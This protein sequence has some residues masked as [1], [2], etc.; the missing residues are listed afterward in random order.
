MKLNRE[1]LHNTKFWDEANIELPKNNIEE[2]IANT[3]INPRWLHFGA[4]NI[5]RAFPGVLQQQLLNKNLSDY[6]IVVAEGYDYEIIDRMYRPQ[7][8]LSLV[9]TLKADG[10]TQ[11]QVISSIVES[12]RVHPTYREDV[13]RLEEIITNPSLEMISFTITEKGYSITNPKGE[14]VG[15]I[16]N[17]LDN[18]L[19]D[20]QTFLGILV[21]N[22]YKRYKQNSAPI[23]LV[24][25]DNVSHNGDKL[26]NAVITIAQE[27]NKKGKVEDGFVDY[28]LDENKVSFPWSMI[29]KI[30]PRP[31][32]TVQKQLEELGYEDATPIITEKG[33]FISTFVNAEEAQYLVIEDKFPNGRPPL[34][35]VGVIFTYKETVDK[36]EKMKVCTCLNPLHTVLAIYGCLL[37]YEKIY[38]EMQDEE[39]VKF[40]KE[41]GYNEGLPVVVNPE[42]IDPKAFI[43][44]VIQVRFANPFMPDTP[45]R[46]ATDTS[47]KLAIRFGETIK[48]YA[49]NPDLN[50]EDLEYI[51]LVIAGWIRYLMGVND[52]GEVFEL[53]A[54]PKLESLQPYIAKL[55]LG[56]ND[57][58]ATLLKPILQ[59]EEIFGVDF[60]ALDMNT[61]IEEYFK[62]LNEGPKAIRNT[63]KRVFTE[64]ESK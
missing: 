16:Q 42:I 49:K 54:D 12:L 51:P 29:D 55:E 9:V 6:G 47:Q 24:S 63:L 25:M 14:I 26:K 32:A 28:L 45:Q 17:D 46:I 8:N 3:N 61:K 43:D 53:S 33:T 7:D 11:K 5:F 62:S 18:N 50:V 23:A 41:V 15:Y 36:I 34:D 58:I 37:G 21:A 1:A 30:T 31:D 56:N 39:L 35:E 13:Q 60:Y 19:E 22:L 40:I 57:N 27:W 44:E 10:T 4:G 38:D 64:E 20:A 2:T 52:E 48:A 59:N